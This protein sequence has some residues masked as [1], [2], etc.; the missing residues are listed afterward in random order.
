M[1]DPEKTNSQYLECK[2]YIS[3]FVENQFPLYFQKHGEKLIEFVKAYYEFEE[4]TNLQFLNVGSCM[5][6]KNDIDTTLDEFVVFFKSK[7]MKDLPFDNVDDNRMIIKHIWELYQSKGS[8]RSIKLLMRMLYGEDVDVYVPGNDVLRPSHSIWYQPNYVEVSHSESNKD[9]IGKTI[10]G[11]NSGASGF[12]QSVVTKNINGRLFDVMY[13][14]DIKGTFQ[15][16]DHLLTDQYNSVMTSKI[17]FGSLTEIQL[18]DYSFGFKVGDLLDV[19]SPN[20]DMAIAKV[21]SVFIN[22]SSIAWKVLD[23][24]FGFQP[25]VLPD[26]T[27]YPDS[28]TEIFISDSIL[29]IVNSGLVDE[30]ILIQRKEVIQ[31]ASAPTANVGD[32]VSFAGL[33]DAVILEINGNDITVELQ[34]D[35]FAAAPTVDINSVT[36]NVNT[37]TDVSTSATVMES[38]SK[39]VWLYNTQNGPF[40]AIEGVTN[41]AEDQFGN[42][43]Q[44]DRSFVGSGASFEIVHLANEE[45]IE[46]YSDVIGDNNALGVPY[47]SLVIGDAN[48]S[49]PKPDSIGAISNLSSVIQNVLELKTTTIGSVENLSFVNPGTGYNAGPRAKVINGITY[50]KYQKEY[51]MRV[52]GGIGFRVGDKLSQD[53]GARGEVVE[54]GSDFVIVRSLSFM[55]QLQSNVITRFESGQ[56]N[57]FSP[58]FSTYQNSNYMGGNLIIG[59]ER[60][61]VEGA[62][63]TVRILSSGFGFQSGEEVQLIDQKGVNPNSTGIATLGGSGITIGNWLSTTSHL[64]WSTYIHDNDYYQDY[65]YEIQS[66]ITPNKYKDVIE[67]INHV[68]GTA[69]FNKVIKTAT[70]EDQHKLT[71]SIEIL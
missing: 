9:Y 68:A 33:T 40:T 49:F 64:N 18:T 35:S 24:G 65:S 38:S 29:S 67:N 36:Y 61:S 11:S 50:Q 27:P 8:K 54:V 7:Y 55:N 47:L 26:G 14:T 53:S 59:T 34:F 17:S 32:T 37:V 43:F 22:E 39:F 5:E 31:L 44:V 16:N 15:P 30:D 3:P 20:G 12:V 60:E 62:I 46:Y 13:M 70:L 42:Q 52:D 58:T 63:K 10:S 66:S 19:K 71:A 6:E 25:T 48:W 1:Y 41:L 23:S 28:Q 57:P 21:D 4:E 56:R 51:V 2:R 45:N 69:L